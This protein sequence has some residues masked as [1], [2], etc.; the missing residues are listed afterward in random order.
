MTWCL[1]TRVLIAALAVTSSLAQNVSILRGI[2][3]D[4]QH[5]PIDHAQIV[6][7]GSGQDFSKSVQSDPNGEFQVENLLNGSSY[8]ITA[9]APGF[10][11]LTEQVS[12]TAGKTPVVHLQLEIGPLNE[13]VEV[14]GA[15][16]KLETQTSTVQTL[17]TP[18]EVAQT[19]GASLTN[20]LAMITD[21]TPG[22]YMVHDMLHMR[23][24]H[25][26]NWF[27]DGIPVINTNIAANVA[28]LINPKNVEELEVE[29]G[30]FSSEY[31]DRTY[32]FFNVVTPSGFERNNDAEL[33]VSAGNFYST[34][35][36][37][38][39]GGHTERF[40]YYASIDGN[41][42]EL[43]LGTPISR[44]LHDQESGEGGF[45]SLLYNP[46]PKDQFRWIA[47][48]RG[49][50]YQIPNT[51]DQQ[52]SGIRDLDL[53]R[54]YLIGFNWAHS[55][56]DGVVFSL[57][58]YLHNNSARYLG[59]PQ[60]TPFVLNDNARSNYFGIRSVLQIE[61]KHHN[62][63]FGFEG[64]AQHDNTFFGLR[65]NAGDQ[66]LHHSELNWANSESL[67]LEDQYKVTSW[68]TLD[69][70]VRLQRYSGLANEK[71]FD[72]RIG[73]AIRIPGL[74]WIV[75]GYYAYYYQPP[76]LDS[77]A[78]PALSFAVTQGF[79]F[80]PLK[81]ERDIQH[82][83]GLSIPLN[84]W[85]LDVDN[86]HTTGR[87]FLDH[88]V[89]SNSGIF[90]PLTL[91]GAVISGTE[92]TVR[93]PRLFHVAQLRVAYSNQ[94]ARGI[95]PITGGLLE[96]APVGNFL[97]D[98]DQRN[99]ATGVLSLNL[100]GHFWATPAYQFGSG[101]LNGIGPSHLPPH[102]TFDLS[103]GKNFRQH[104][105]ASLNAVNIAN[106]RYLLDTSNTFGGTHYINPR[107]IYGELRYRF[108]L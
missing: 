26:V 57:T 20:S 48:L 106:T 30:G 75:H 22:A 82:D 34:D 96:S 51:G 19:P 7:K 107:Q 33:I 11:P 59:G 63:R 18:Q 62:A 40:A 27:F 73:G 6:V 105:S 70:G 28:P 97:L 55:M 12:V 92:V 14:S 89:I 53:E 102:S 76:P 52:A 15:T 72:P 39:I 61:K 32:G 47:S 94:T 16:S 41:R 29:R 3:H 25:Q 37:F 100:P 90:V 60:D 4:P 36:Q 88:D 54:D 56:S 98:H 79:G 2:V 38:S 87:N 93:S 24:G 69:L 10:R 9:S 43:G 77:L 1:Y 68:L 35:D 64:W 103:V 21:F 104:W 50:H 91:V 44:A 85:S 95:G 81:G 66:V 86:F 23:G 99:S 8:S 101:F 84:N 5:R 13:T 71:A 65:A 83:I 78:G 58:P 67:F 31:G 42:S 49:D 45:L 46:T 17:V 74:R 80:I 108:H